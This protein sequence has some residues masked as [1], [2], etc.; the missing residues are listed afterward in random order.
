MWT[1]F[2][3]FMILSIGRADVNAVVNLVGMNNNF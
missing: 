2:M 1:G 3:W